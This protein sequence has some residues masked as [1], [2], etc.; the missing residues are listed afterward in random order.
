MFYRP[1]F[2]SSL[3]GSAVVSLVGL[4]LALVLGP[5]LQ[6]VL[7]DG[8]AAVLV[9]ILVLGG[10]MLCGFLVARPM[11]EKQAP[12]RRIAVNI[13]PGALIGHLGVFLPLATFSAAPGNAVLQTAGD[14]LIGVIALLGGA[15]IARTSSRIPA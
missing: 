4:V 6:L 12:M 3:I 1:G 13:V 11:W 8:A 14:C 7:G 9:A 2:W 15:L 10:R 5:S